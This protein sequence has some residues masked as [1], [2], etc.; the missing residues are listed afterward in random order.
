VL[1][2]VNALTG[3]D[4]LGKSP[5]GTVLQGVDIISGPVLGA[6]QLPG[7]SKAIILL[8]EFLQV[9]I[10]LPKKLLFCSPF[11]VRRHMCIL[12]RRRTRGRL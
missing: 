12:R 3:A 8:D 9:R 10:N 1:F 5:A 11:L 2:H 7:S 6:Y 4:A